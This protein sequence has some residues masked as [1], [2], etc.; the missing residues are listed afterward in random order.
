MVVREDK[1]KRDFPLFTEKELETFINLW[2]TIAKY[3]RECSKCNLAS[4][5][6]PLGGIDFNFIIEECPIEEVRKT[7]KELKIMIEMHEKRETLRNWRDEQ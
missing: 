6:Y 3:D 2:K 7:A 1:I 5:C 4:F